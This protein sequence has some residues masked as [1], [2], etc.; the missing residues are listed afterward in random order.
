MNSK[1]LKNT[2]EILKAM[3]VNGETMEQLIRDLGMEDQMLRQLVMKSDVDTLDQLIKEKKELDGDEIQV[4]CIDEYNIQQ[5][6]LLYKGA[7]YRVEIKNWDGD[8]MCIVSDLVTGT[9]IHCAD[10]LFDELTD[11]VMNGVLAK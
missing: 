2:I 9:E 7:E 1:I 5:V 11:C 8:S 6:D 4:Y 3:D 10:P